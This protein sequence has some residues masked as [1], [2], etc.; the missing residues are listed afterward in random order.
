VLRHI[1]AF[2]RIHCAEVKKMGMLMA[3][4]LLAAVLCV[5]G[6]ASAAGRARAPWLRALGGSVCGAAA[7]GAINFFASYTGV[8]IA[9]NYVTAFVVVVLGAPGAVL[10][11]L[12]RALLLL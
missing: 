6:V 8:T 9:L 5:G 12:A 10:L 3:L 7:L 2:S 1:D 4:E 11:L